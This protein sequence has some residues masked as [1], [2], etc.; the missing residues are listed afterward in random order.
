[1]I[2]DDS[3]FADIMGSEYTHTHVH[4][5]LLLT[6]LLAHPSNVVVKLQS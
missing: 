1:M 6:L 5:L 4:T 3:V 2:Q